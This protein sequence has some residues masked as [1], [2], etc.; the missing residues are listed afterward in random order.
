MKLFLPSRY[1]SSNCDATFLRAQREITTCSTSS[2]SLYSL[3]PPMTIKTLFP[4]STRQN[5][6]YYTFTQVT[7]QLRVALLLGWVK[8]CSFFKVLSVSHISLVPLST[9]QHE[10]KGPSCGGEGGGCRHSEMFVLICHYY[11]WPVERGF[12]SCLESTVTFTSS[13][14]LHRNN[15][16]LFKRELDGENFPCFFQ[17]ASVNCTT[18]CQPCSLTDQNPA[19][20]I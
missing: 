16:R 6:L 15:K 14:V 3:S 7:V 5:V 13:K 19:K 12:E 17:S 20:G 11:L 8:S 10:E 2:S 4:W 1:S 18:L 9:P